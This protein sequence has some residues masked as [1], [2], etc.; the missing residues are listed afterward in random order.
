MSTA[1]APIRN[2]GRASTEEVANER[3]DEEVVT[4]EDE[5]GGGAEETEERGGLIAAEH[6]RH[7]PSPAAAMQK[8][9]ELSCRGLL[10]VV[11][12]A[13]SRVAG[14]DLIWGGGSWVGWTKGREEDE[15]R[16]ALPGGQFCPSEVRPW[17]GLVGKK[18]LW[19][20]K[21]LHLSYILIFDLFFIII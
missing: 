14:S 12:A 8:L 11:D 21:C 13:T 19:D 4:W 18:L 2:L 7:L 9:G 5:R 3:A 17:D 15:R 6:R 20:V 16:T 1:R 10:L